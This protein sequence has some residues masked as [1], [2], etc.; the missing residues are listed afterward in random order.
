MKTKKIRKL[1]F[2]ELVGIILG[3][4]HIY[5]YPP[6]HIYGLEISGN[7]S[8]DRVFF[9]RIAGYLEHFVG[10][11][12][13][14]RVKI[15]TFGKSLQLLVYDKKFAYRLINLGIPFKNKS[16][17]ATIPSQYLSWHHSQHV[18]RGLF[19]TDGSLYFSKVGG[20]H[21]YPRLEIKSSSNELIKQIF[22][23]LSRQ[24]YNPH[25]IVK[26]SDK[27]SAVYISGPHKIDKWV[28]EI[29][30]GSQK[31][32]SKYLLWKNLGHYLPKSTL[33]ERLKRLHNS[34]VE[35]RGCPS[36]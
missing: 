11:R 6:Y 32:L 23:I 25:I 27:T 12:P 28:K 26:K 29:G 5:H 2:P 35:A 24:G 14:I 16:F 34:S 31:N 4:G 17:T 36:G 22:G 19:E 9:N 20:K 10:K 7:A 18:L 15:H 21:T 33:E 8:E 3:D 1:N 13:K 30:F